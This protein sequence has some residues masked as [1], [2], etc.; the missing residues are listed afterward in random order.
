MS[1]ARRSTPPRL[2]RLL[3]AAALKAL[4]PE[5]AED[6]ARASTCWHR[7]EE[8]AWAQL[9]EWLRAWSRRPDQPSASREPPLGLCSPTPR[10]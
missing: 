9:E 8:E 4:P 7:G 1:W 10:S 5:K 6:V 2:A 3:L